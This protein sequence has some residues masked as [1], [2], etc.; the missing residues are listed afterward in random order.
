MNVKAFD[1][2]P[3]AAAWLEV[4]QKEIEDLAARTRTISA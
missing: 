3:D 4:D 2:L 1:N